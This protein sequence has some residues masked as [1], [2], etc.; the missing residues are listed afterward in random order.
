MLA[1]HGLPEGR[2]ASQ[3]PG[4]HP[5]TPTACT[6]L[7]AIEDI[8]RCGRPSS[9]RLP[10]LFADLPVRS[11]GHRRTRR[12][13]QLANL[14]LPQFW[15]PTLP[16][17]S[18]SIRGRRRDTARAAEAWAVLYRAAQHRWA[19]CKSGAEE[20]RGGL[21]TTANLPPVTVVFPW[22]TPP[23]YK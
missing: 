13:W 9:S 7:S 12:P 16:T 21:P 10:R 22:R 14:P 4:R 11:G 18:H 8:A 19:Q 15:D 6:C 5:R 3:R 2:P 17:P 23:P 1:Q 20:Q